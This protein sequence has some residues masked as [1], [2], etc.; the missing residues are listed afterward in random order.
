[1]MLLN[2]AANAR[3]AMPHGGLFEIQVFDADGMAG[4]RLADSGHGMDTQ[5]Q[6]RIFE[7]FFSTKDASVGTG[8]G[9]SVI[10][11]LVRAAGGDIRVDSAPG[12]G[13][14]FVIRLPRAGNAIQAPAL[15]T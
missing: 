15:N 13:T 1:M 4:I 7:P 8:L 3:D 2:V 9:L 10:Q 12:H 6:R 11:D 5:V 14:T